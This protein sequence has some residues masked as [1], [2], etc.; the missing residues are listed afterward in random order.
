MNLQRIY[1]PTLGRVSKQI[2]YDNMPTWVQDITYFVIQPHE[3]EVFRITYQNS[4]I[5][6]L[7]KEIKGI[8][9]TREWI[10]N[11][12]GDTCYGV[13]DDDIKFVK[14]NINRKTLKK[15]SDKSN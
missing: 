7:P 6:V 12:G 11:D 9:R 10:I 8:A 14:R 4:N 1:I 13:F 2:T 3:E 5:K 15:N